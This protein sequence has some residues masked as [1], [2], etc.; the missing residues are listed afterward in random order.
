MNDDLKDARKD[1]CMNDTMQEL[2]N[3]W[4]KEIKDEKMNA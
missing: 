1:E 2:M 4:M 3:A